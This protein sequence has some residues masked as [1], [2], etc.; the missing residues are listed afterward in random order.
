VPVESWLT[1]TLEIQR[2]LV[3]SYFIV[4]AFIALFA[5]FLAWRTRFKW[6]SLYLWLIAGII[7]LLWEAILFG[8]GSRQYTLFAVGE[9]LY[10]AL[11]EG[12]PGLIITVLFANWVG[13]IDIDRYKDP[14][15]TLPDEE[16]APKDE[17]AP[18]EPVDDE[19]SAGPI[20]EDGGE[21]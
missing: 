17:E 4:M 9:L 11:T 19:P 5:I 16:P 20:N 1:D 21:G 12:G 8:I 14:E 10:H 18:E 15:Q 7:G 3:N 2:H 6:L 13:I